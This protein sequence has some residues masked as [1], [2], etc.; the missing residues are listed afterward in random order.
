MARKTRGRMGLS[1]KQKTWVLI[2]ISTG[3][4][5]G[6]LY[7]EQ[8]AF[9]YVLATLSVTVLLAVVALADLS[10]AKAVATTLAAG[11][12]ALP[13]ESAASE[14][15]PLAQSTFGSRQRKRRT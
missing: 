3:I 15:K 12:S 6:L 1:Q 4:V 5:V 14:I 8:I 11:G 2:I 13:V 10:G 7:W 9:L